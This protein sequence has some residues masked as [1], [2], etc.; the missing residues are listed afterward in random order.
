MLD[1]KKTLVRAVSGAV[2][3]LIIVLACWWG[4]LGVTLL[5]GIFGALG[6]AEF[7]RMQFDNES[8]SGG[9]GL[10]DVM[11]GLALIFS[12][13]PSAS[14]PY[15]FFFVWIAWLIGR[16][17]VT[18]YSHHDHPER[19][20]AVDITSHIYIAF[21]LAI[22]VAMGLFLQAA[23]NTCMPL[24][25]MFILI[26]VNDTGAF[27]FGSTFGK[28]PLFERVSPKKSWEGFWGGLFCCLAIGALIGLTRSPLAA[29]H[30]GNPVIFWTIAGGVISVAS[31]FG[32]LFESVIKRNLNKKDSGN[33]IPGHGGILDRIDSL[34]LVIPTMLLY[35]LFYNIILG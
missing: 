6:I 2:Y 23:V 30:I 10:Y 12:P 22:L 31:T 26:W 14:I 1:A 4:D 7:R 25:A 11:G 35:Y 34:L 3:V 13:L 21:P 18:I 28:H 15:P 32:D 24:L 27:L 29:G 20:F 19:V 33:L 16:M 5:A 8:S 17:V 9:L